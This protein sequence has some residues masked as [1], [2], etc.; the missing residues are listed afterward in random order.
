MDDAFGSSLTQTGAVLGT[1]AYMSPEQARGEKVD[2]ATDIYSLGAVLYRLVTGARPFEGVEPAATIS[3]LL[4]STP[5]RPRAVEPSVP[6]ALEIVI[7]RAMAERSQDRFVSMEEFAAALEPFDTGEGLA[8][9]SAAPAKSAGAVA[10]MARARREARSAR[11]TVAIVGSIAVICLVLALADLAAAGIRLLK[12]ADLSLV[13]GVMV[14]VGVLAMVSTPLVI[15]LR[16]AF[17]GFWSNTAR[18]VDLAHA[19]KRAVIV[20]LAAYGLASLVVRF[21][22]AFILREA[23]VAIGPLGSSILLAVAIGA[24]FSTIAWQRR[25]KS[26]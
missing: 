9:G 16:K 18:A 15:F 11:P 17:R 21:A 24:G 26:R 3:A 14:F 25:R 6:E 1:P 8:E 12:G 4:T 22:S 7:Q 19:L 20:A 23:A 13:E 5:A 10:E 2:R